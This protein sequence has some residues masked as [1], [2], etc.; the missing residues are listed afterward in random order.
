VQH[1]HKFWSAIT[2]VDPVGHRADPVCAR[3]SQARVVLRREPRPLADGWRG[4]FCGLHR[5]ITEKHAS[6]P[7][8]GRSHPVRLPRGRMGARFL[9]SV[10]RVARGKVRCGMAFASKDPPER[11]FADS[12]S[13]LR[14]TIA[15]SD[16]M[17]AETPGSRSYLS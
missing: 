6:K 10:G 7:P 1:G 16:N 17:A 2:C 8:S 12:S 4:N 9:L 15:R 5:E 14:L 3:P 11:H 13:T